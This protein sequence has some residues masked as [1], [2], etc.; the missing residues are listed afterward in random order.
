M[1]IHIHNSRYISIET[2]YQ[3]SLHKQNGFPP[4]PTGLLTTHTGTTKKGLA[5]LWLHPQQTFSTHGPRA[6]QSITSES[7]VSPRC[8]MMTFNFSCGSSY[9]KFFLE[10]LGICS[11][12][13]FQTK[14][15]GW[16][17][18]VQ[19]IWIWLKLNVTTCIAMVF[20]SE[21]GVL[22]Y[23]FSPCFSFSHR[24]PRNPSSSNKGA[25]LCPHRED[26]DLR[27]VVVPRARIS[28]A[29]SWQEIFPAN[30]V[31]NGIHPL[32]NTF[33]PKK[34]TGWIIFTNLGKKWENLWNT[35]GP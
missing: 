4:T 11:S 17:N 25:A 30:D 16:A 10:F 33:F 7:A 22:S 20:H 35:W 34:M 3:R 26:R 23:I 27:C 19:R 12:N 6:S 1:N 28:K 2:N 18:E 8:S 14:C 32:N 31:P 29:E 13:S 24:Y 15:Q 21:C 5:P 9:R